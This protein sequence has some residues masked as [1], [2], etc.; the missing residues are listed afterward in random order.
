MEYREKKDRKKMVIIHSGIM[1]DKSNSKMRR[2]EQ[3]KIFEEIMAKFFRFH[4]KYKST[5]LKLSK[6]HMDKKTQNYTKGT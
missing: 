4:E 5:D 3:K 6:K 2:E 1:S